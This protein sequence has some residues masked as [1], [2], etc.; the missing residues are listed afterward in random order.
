MTR[1]GNVVYD[2]FFSIRLTPINGIW[3]EIVEA[4]DSACVLLVNY[5]TCQIFL[6][7][8]KRAPMISEFNPD[9]FI[10]E[11]VAGRMDECAVRDNMARE[12][13]EETGISVNPKNIR[14][15]NDGCALASTPGMTNEHI[16]L[17][18]V[19]VPDDQIPRAGK[20]GGLAEEGESTEIVAVSFDDLYSYIC[21]D[22]KTFALIQTLRIEVLI[23]ERS[24]IR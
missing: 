14:L 21:E 22:M 19:T 16:F 10:I 23:A 24:R 6:V 7:R 8:Q 13:E 11:T 2:G 1:K 12:I 15:I 18:I 9:G 17:G 4:K 3:R 5:K 20:R